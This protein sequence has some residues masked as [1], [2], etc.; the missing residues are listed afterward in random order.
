MPPPGFFLGHPPA[1]PPARPPAGPGHAP[2]A[3]APPGARSPPPR[4]AP[5]APPGAPAG[6]GKE[7]WP[8]EEKENHATR[9]EIEQENNK[10]M[11][12]ELVVPYFRR[13]RRPVAFFLSGLVRNGMTPIPTAMCFSFVLS[14]FLGFGFLGGGMGQLVR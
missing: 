9:A 5:S 3:A 2:G 8:R 10:N 11:R 12:L 7:T 1:P 13:P 4:A 14:L 6:A